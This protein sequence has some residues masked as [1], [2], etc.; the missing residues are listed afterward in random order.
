MQSQCADKSVAPTGLTHSNM[1]R[2][3]KKAHI[4]KSLA[5]I[6]QRSTRR[7]AEA[8]RWPPNVLSALE[9]TSGVYR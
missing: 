8:T 4:C 7:I 3:T 5:L 2:Q 6:T 9:T 1:L